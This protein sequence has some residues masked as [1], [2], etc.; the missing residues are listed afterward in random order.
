[1][2]N[3]DK[4]IIKSAEQKKKPLGAYRG[5]HVHARCLP[6]PSPAVTCLFVLEGTWGFSNFVAAR[7]ASGNFPLL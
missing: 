4:L 1:M 5:L 6:R 3:D 2:Q 7:S